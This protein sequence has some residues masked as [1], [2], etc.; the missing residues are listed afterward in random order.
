M[1][2][3]ATEKAAPAMLNLDDF[4]LQGEAERGATMPVLDPKTGDPTGATVQVYGADARSYRVALRRLR[5]AAAREMEREPTDEDDALLLGRARAAAAA[6]TG[7]SGIGVKGE[8]VEHSP[9]S[10]V[11]VMRAYPWLADQVIAYTNNR[12]NFGKV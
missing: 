10:A 2:K 9:E 12:G 6:I 11:E 5:D 8:A 3:P 7:W 1:T 4:D